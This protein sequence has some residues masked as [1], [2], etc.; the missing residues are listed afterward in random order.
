MDVKSAFLNVILKEEIY[1]EQPQGFIAAEQENKVCRLKRALYGL[2]Q[3]SR[4]WNQQFHGVLTT[5][6]FEWTYSDAGIYV[7]H[8]HGGNSLLI[9]VLYV[10]DITIMGSS[11][12]DVKQLKEKLSLR[13][14]MSDLGEIQLYLGMRICRVCSKERIETDPSRYIRSTRDRFGMADANP[15]PTPLP[16]GADVHL[17]KNIAQATQAEIKHFQSLI[18]S[19]LYVQIGTRPDISFAVSHL[20][21]YATNPTPQHLCLATYVLSYLLG[22]AD[23]CL[24]YDG[25]NGSGLHG[26]SDSSLGDQTDD[27][28]STSSYVYIL[29]NGAISWSSC[30]QRTAAQNTTEAEYMAMTNA[31]NQVAWYRSFLTELGY[32]VDDPIPLHGDNKGA[33]DLAL[34][35]V[36]RRRSKH[37]DIKYHVIRWYIEKG[38]I[39]LICTPT[40]EMV[41]DGFT[42]SLSHVLLHRFNSGMGLSA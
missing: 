34:N 22:T 17:I 42:K 4:T 20:V 8:Q 7:H 37:I 40:E 24:C 30:K 38:Y 26:Y 2:K 16:A 41:A 19:L 6:G 32:S 15:H 29:M 5:L 1:M 36:T 10:D 25:T 35:P 31:A 28:H 14:E 18:G 12:E 23:K 9:V 33:I 11:L 39:S 27:R 21:Q 3:A 13:Y